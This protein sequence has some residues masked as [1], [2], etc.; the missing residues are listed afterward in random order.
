MQITV[1]LMSVGGTEDSASI[2]MS[3]CIGAGVSAGGSARGNICRYVW[4]G[5]ARRAL[6]LCTGICRSLPMLHFCRGANIRW[7]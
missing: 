4:T 6:V 7:V 2:T 1:D 5:I 3:Y